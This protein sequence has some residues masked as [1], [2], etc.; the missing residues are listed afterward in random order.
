MIEKKVIVHDLLIN[1]YLTESLGEAA[2]TAIFLHGWRA[3]AMIWIPVIKLL[4]GQGFNTY[5][6]DLPGFG[7]SQTPR[8]AWHVSDYSNAVY[9]FIKK[10]EL[11]DVTVIGHSFGGRVGIK[12]AAEHP[13]CLAKL[14]LVD[15]SGLRLDP[16]KRRVIT[17]IAKLLKPAFALPFLK[18]LRPKIYYMLGAED[19]LATPELKST[20]INIIEEDLGKWL[21]KIKHKT[22][23]VWGGL[24]KEV[25]LRVGQIMQQKIPNSSMVVFPKAGHFCFMDEPQEFVNTLIKFIRDEPI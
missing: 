8:A 7:R 1:Y 15:S 11:K 13:D 6:I 5:R 22:L 2:Q 3:N 4:Q 18:T 25:P 20:F 21:P 23:L 17:R 24:D 9:E 10:L 14:V 12:L 16:Y 19:Y